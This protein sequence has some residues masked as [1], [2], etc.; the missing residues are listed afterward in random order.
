MNLLLDI[1]RASRKDEETPIDDRHTKRLI[2][3]I[4]KSVGGN[5]LFQS[6][7]ATIFSR[8]SFKQL[9][10]VIANF[11]RITGDTIQQCIERE[12]KQSDYAKA[13]L[14]IGAFLA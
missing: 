12:P 13:L 5:H 2:Q 11:S 1:L 10:H 8:E 14:T 4:H 3:L 6:S 9:Y 7:I